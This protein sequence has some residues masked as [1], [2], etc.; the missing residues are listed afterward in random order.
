MSHFGCTQFD[1]ILDDGQHFIDHQLKSFDILFKNV[2]PGG[3]YIIE[4]IS[5][6]DDL[7]YGRFGL[8]YPQFWGQKRSDC[9]D[10]T[11]H[12]FKTYINGGKLESDYISNVN[13]IVD[14]I[15]DIFMYEGDSR[16]IDGTNIEANSSLRESSRTLVIKKKY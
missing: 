15:D 8:P 5:H 14:N 12:V 16:R 9:T 6:I 3:Y 4:D 7:L 1:M 11:Y 10:C 2:K 13:N